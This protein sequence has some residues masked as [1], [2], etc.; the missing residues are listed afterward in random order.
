MSPDGEPERSED[1]QERPVFALKDN[2][3]HR[4]EW[5]AHSEALWQ[6]AHRI[7]SSDSR[8]DAGDVS[9]ALRCL[10][11]S[12]TERLRRGLTRVRPRAHAG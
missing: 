7:A 10:E 5:W 9:H 4:D 3:A 2:A 6:K 8:L 1:P 12:A 11:L